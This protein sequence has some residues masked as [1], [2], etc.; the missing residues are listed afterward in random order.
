MVREKN[1]NKNKSKY[2]KNRQPNVWGNPIG[3]E[4]KSKKKRRK[5]WVV[6]GVL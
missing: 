1:R 6:V 5:G 2:K 4:K 3:V